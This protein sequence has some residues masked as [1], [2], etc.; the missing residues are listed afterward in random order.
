MELALG[1][2][3][4]VSRSRGQRITVTQGA[5]HGQ[6][7][8]RH[9]KGAGE[10]LTEFEQGNDWFE[11]AFLANLYGLLVEMKLVLPLTFS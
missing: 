10:P 3:R 5:A 1:E 4:R 9:P 11:S 6:R 8:G 7:F 2:G